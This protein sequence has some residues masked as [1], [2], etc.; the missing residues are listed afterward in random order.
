MGW[1]KAA[2]DIGHY[3][4]DDNCKHDV[5]AGGGGGSGGGGLD[6]NG[7]SSNNEWRQTEN[8]CGQSGEGWAWAKTM[9]ALIRMEARLQ[10]I[11]RMT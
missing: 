10:M 8:G 5:D 1:A 4:G 9:A 6:D 11:V 2:D 7:S 3:I